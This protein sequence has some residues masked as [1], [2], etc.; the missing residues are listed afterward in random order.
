M[1]ILNHIPTHQLKDRQYISKL[2]PTL[3]WNE[4]HKPFLVQ[5]TSMKRS[6]ALQGA[7]VECGGED[8]E[9][10]KLTM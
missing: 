7:G 8:S 9:F 6:T 2:C 10:P 4:K 5:Q 1:T 3:I